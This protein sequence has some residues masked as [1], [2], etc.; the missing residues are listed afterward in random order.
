VKSRCLVFLLIVLVA[1]R[2]VAFAAQ[3]AAPLANVTIA[4]TSISPQYSP[5]WIAKE[6]G[7]FRKNGINAQLQ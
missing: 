5:A 2:C 3:S 7:I 1:A 4:Y 6:T